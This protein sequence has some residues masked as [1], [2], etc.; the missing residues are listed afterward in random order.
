MCSVSLCELNHIEQNKFDIHTFV[1]KHRKGIAHHNPVNSLAL[2]SF[3]NNLP[4][5]T[6]HKYRRNDKEYFQEIYQKKVEEG[7][8]EKGNI[9]TE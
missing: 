8:S 1:S 7:N 3:P 5:E 6:H 2:F 4:K 9:E